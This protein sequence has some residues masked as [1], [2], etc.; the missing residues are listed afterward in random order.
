M[1]SGLFSIILSLTDSM[2]ST[3]AA[4]LLYQLLQFLKVAFS[5]AAA[6]TDG[7]KE[8]C[9]GNNRLVEE[10]QRSAAHTEGSRLPEEVQSALSLPVV[11]LSVTSPAQSVVQVSVVLHHLHPPLPGCK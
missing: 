11:S 4:S 7:C 5:A 1:L 3:A 10:M 2:G 8:S 6:P 9:T